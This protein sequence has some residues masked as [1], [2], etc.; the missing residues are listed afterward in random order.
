MN[1]EGVIINR[2]VSFKVASKLHSKRKG[3]YGDQPRLGD[4]ISILINNLCI[5]MA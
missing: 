2:C 5:A 3:R 4:G 1:Q